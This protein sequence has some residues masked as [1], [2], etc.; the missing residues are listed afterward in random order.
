MQKPPLVAVDTNFPVLLAAGDELAVDALETVRLKIRPA[1]VLVSPT[2]L[3]ELAHKRECDPDLRLRHLA[4]KALVNLRAVWRFHPA[5]LTS[6]QEGLVR[7]AVQQLRH[8]GLIPYEER[9]DASVVAESAVLNSVL[10]VSNDSHLLD[11]DHRQL[12]LLFR[13]LDLPVPLIVSPREIV[14]KFYR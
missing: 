7:N 11:I 14:H 13:E 12:G 2:V 8:S 9:N 4:G 3:Q 5:L 10:L 1:Q 6:L